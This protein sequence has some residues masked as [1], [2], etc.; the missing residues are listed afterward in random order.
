MVEK[1]KVFSVKERY[2]KRF[3]QSFVD[4]LELGVRGTGRCNRET[5]IKNYTLSRRGRG[6][7]W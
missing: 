7:W 5:G 3:P 2:I 4:C 6:E 1:K